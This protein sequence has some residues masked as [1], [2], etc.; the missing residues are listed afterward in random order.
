ME[1][2]QGTVDM[3]QLRYQ[4]YCDEKLLVGTE[5]RE[6]AITVARDFDKQAAPIEWVHVFDSVD[7]E[8][9]WSDH[10]LTKD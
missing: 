10:A 6:Y 7:D 9:I 5:L 4:V 8:I 1:L 3:L 2:T